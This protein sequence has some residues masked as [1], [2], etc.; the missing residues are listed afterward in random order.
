MN[1]FEQIW[2]TLF[3]IFLISFLISVVIVF[4]SNGDIFPIFLFYPIFIQIFLTI[5]YMIIYLIFEYI[6]D[7]NIPFFHNGISHYFY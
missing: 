6:W 2:Y 7:I 3:V 1:L 5:V 4:I